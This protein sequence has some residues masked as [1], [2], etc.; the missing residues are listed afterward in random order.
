MILPAIVWAGI[1]QCLRGRTRLSAQPHLHAPAM[2]WATMVRAVWQQTLQRRALQWVGPPGL[3]RFGQACTGRCRWHCTECRL[4]TSGVPIREPRHHQRSRCPQG[5]FHRR[6]QGRSLA[7]CGFLGGGRRNGRR[8]GAFG[9]RQDDAAQ[10]SLGTGH[11]RP[12]I[13]GDRRTVARATRRPAPDPVPGPPHGVYLSVV[14]PAAGHQR[15]R[16]T[17]NWHCW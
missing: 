4:T 7:G 15:D 1:S 6:F 8:H 10:L 14:Q 16:K 11:L 9:L 3:N 17:W 12:R 13:G 2:D 5:L